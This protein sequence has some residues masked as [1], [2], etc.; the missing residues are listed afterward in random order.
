[1]E[2]GEEKRNEARSKEGQGEEKEDTEKADQAKNSTTTNGAF[3]GSAE[4]RDSSREVEAGD[5]KTRQINIEPP[6]AAQDLDDIARKPARESPIAAAGTGPSTGAASYD[7]PLDSEGDHDMRNDS[8]YRRKERA[9]QDK[10]T[11]REVPKHA[12]DAPTP[13]SEHQHI[14]SGYRLLGGADIAGE[15]PCTNSYGEDLKALAEA[16]EK[17]DEGG[18]AFVHVHKHSSSNRGLGAIHNLATNGNCVHCLFERQ[19]RS[20]MPH[21]FLYTYGRR[22][23]GEQLNPP[24]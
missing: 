3:S 19:R 13:P 16:C 8:E 7:A 6:D 10:M 24:G 5:R 14:S 1:M 21:R 20:K 15:C 12:R 17:Q 9:M 18:R 11:S 23:G 2:E 22:L 4:K